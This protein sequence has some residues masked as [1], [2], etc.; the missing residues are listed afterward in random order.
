[1]LNF[2]YTAG[3]LVWGVMTLSIVMWWL[4]AQAYRHQS[5]CR[6]R[7]VPEITRQ[8]N[9]QIGL[10]NHRYQSVCRAWLN[11][12]EQQ[13]NQGIP[14]ISILVKVLP[15]LGL[16]GTVDGMIES[17]QQ[18]N[19][20]DIQRQLSGGISQALLTTLSGLVTSLSG[21]YFVHHLNQRKRR[22]LASLRRQLE[23][24]NAFSS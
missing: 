14:W 13:L 16:L 12:A 1:M 21:V 2:I 24:Q 18:L 10:S 17:F 11:Q 9:L 20:L 15:L 4:I 22:Y 19:Q 8:Y 23:V 5:R 6:A 3:P 7:F